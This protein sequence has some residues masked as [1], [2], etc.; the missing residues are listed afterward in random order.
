MVTQ[1]KLASCERSGSKALTQRLKK[2]G[3]HVFS[4]YRRLVAGFSWSCAPSALVRTDCFLIY[5]TFIG[6]DAA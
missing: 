2:R 3:E 1:S 6:T 5:V 4:L